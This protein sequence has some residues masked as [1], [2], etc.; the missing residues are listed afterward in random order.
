MK[1]TTL[2]LMLLMFNT[3]LAA[4]I[5]FGTATRVSLPAD[6]DTP[7]ETETITATATDTLTPTDT[8]TETL[9]PTETETATLTPSPTDT[10]TPTLTFT[11]SLTPT[12]TATS[13][14]IAPYPGAP[15]CPDVGMA[16]DTSLFHTLWD[17]VRGCHYDHEHGAN[18]FMPAV[19]AAFPGY[20]L[21][22]LLG[23]VGIGHTNPSSPME[24]SMK[25]GGFKWQV[26]TAAPKGCAVGFESGTVAV[27]A[28]AIQ[29]HN[30]GDYSMEFE[31]RNHTTAALLRQCK[32]GDPSDKGY[33]FVTQLQEYGQRI[34]K[35][36]GT[37]LNYPDNFLPTWPAVDG[38]YFSINCSGNGLPGC[39]TPGGVATSIWTSKPTGTIINKQTGASLRPETSRLFR[40]LFRVRDNYQVLDSNDTTYPFTFIWLCGGA[41]FNPVGCRYNNSTSTIHEI[42]GDIPA[43]W[44]GLAGFDTDPRP[45]RITAEG[46]VTA[47][48][49]LAPSCTS[50]GPCFYPIK[51]VSAFVG[52]YSSDICTTKCSNPDP[53][54][55]PE[56]DIYFCNGVLCLETSPG[57]VPS[58]WIGSGN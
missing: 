26:S 17:S 41:T 14:P 45:G 9:T 8:P 52:K 21:Y 28:Y 58:G 57:A 47:F 34:A 18:P 27:D 20:N 22:A 2:A 25:H 32:S 4:S 23:G 12:L 30:F 54:N 31:T 35:Y 16:H 24:N 49:V 38:P 55:T 29:F 51:M 33:I 48:G 13:T 15:L 3:L 39:P 7:T 46:F 40:L 44:D 42:A 5:S 36:Q 43:S 56:R 37:V 19:A 10:L 1:R 50:A 11:P 53:N 6:A